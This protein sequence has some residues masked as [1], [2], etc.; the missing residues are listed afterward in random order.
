M[1]AAIVNG[2]FNLIANLASMLTTPLVN[3]ITAL[4]PRIR[5]D[6]IIYSYVFE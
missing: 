3:A 5:Y 6:V 2:L 4:I 1:V